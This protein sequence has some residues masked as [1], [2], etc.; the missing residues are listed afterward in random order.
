MRLGHSVR[1]HST[2]VADVATGSDLT[3][4]ADDKKDQQTVEHRH[5]E[6]HRHENKPDK[7][8]QVIAAVAGGNK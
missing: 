2:T 4:T 3:M 8:P 1:G 7:R 6:H 5:P